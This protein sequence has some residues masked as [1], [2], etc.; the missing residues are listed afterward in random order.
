MDIEINNKKIIWIPQDILNLI[1][2]FYTPFH[3]ILKYK[4][5][6]EDIKIYRYFNN[7]KPYGSSGMP[8]N[9][10]IKI[11]IFRLNYNREDYQRQIH[12]RILDEKLEG[13]CHIQHYIDIYYKDS[14]FIRKK[15]QNKKYVYPLRWDNFAMMENDNFY[16]SYKEYCYNNIKRCQQYEQRLQRQN[17]TCN[18]F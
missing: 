12:Y 17:K 3:L 14:V 7:I 6:N 18:I 10:S 16:K 11:Y 9:A 15:N 2:N 5:I 8:Y 1:Y 4:K 13:V